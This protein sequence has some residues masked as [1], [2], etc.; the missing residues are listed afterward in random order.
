MHD[1][2]NVF[3]CGER[4]HKVDACEKW[5]RYLVQPQGSAIN[6]NI[7]RHIKQHFKIGLLYDF[8]Q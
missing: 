5:D 2:E 1:Q 6:H 7:F 3:L 4:V 8:R